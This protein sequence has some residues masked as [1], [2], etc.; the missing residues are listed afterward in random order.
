MLIS[1]INLQ[2]IIKRK[3]KKKGERFS[4]WSAATCRALVVSDLSLIL[5]VRRVAHY[6]SGDLSPHSKGENRCPYKK[7]NKNLFILN[8]YT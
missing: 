3:N 5:D 7:Q 1:L 8:E 2:Q 6:E 4:L